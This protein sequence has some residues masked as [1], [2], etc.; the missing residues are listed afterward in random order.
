MM[1]VAIALTVFAVAGCF[2]VAYSPYGYGASSYYGSY[3][4]GYPYSYWPYRR[5][6][7]D[8][9]DSDSHGYHDHHGGRYEPRHPPRR[10]LRPQRRHEEPAGHPNA[11]RPPGKGP[12]AKPSKDSPSAGKPWKANP[13]AG[14]PWKADPSA[15]KP[16]KANPSAGKPVHG[17]PVAPRQPLTRGFKASVPGPAPMRSFHTGGISR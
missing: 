6:Y 10:V 11:P 17:G 4:R 13:S 14:K 7:H 8:D 15:G 2:P 16:W 5:H 1:R 9:C 3:W 12:T